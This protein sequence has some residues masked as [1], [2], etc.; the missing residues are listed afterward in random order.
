MAPPLDSGDY[1]I[2]LAEVSEANKKGE[3]FTDK[4]GNHY[5]MFV[6]DVR[7]HD[8]NRLFDRFCFDE[9]C[10]FANI[11]LGRFKQFQE[12]CGVDTEKPGD[13]DDLVGK[14]CVATVT[15]KVIKG[16]DGQDRTVNNIM[17]Y[18][19]LSAENGK[20]SEDDEDLPF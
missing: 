4:H 2:R 20:S 19:P 14:R 11:Q 8:G 9:D 5:T 3:P 6:F 16:S 7:E 18:L 15:K 10:D 1:I 12:A 17:Q 13:T